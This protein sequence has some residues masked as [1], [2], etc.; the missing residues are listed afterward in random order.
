MLRE[1]FAGYRPLVT[2]T[3]LGAAAAVFD[4]VTAGLTARR[5]AGDLARLRDSALVTLGRTHARLVTALLGSTVASHLADAGHDDAEPWGAAMKAHG[6][7][8]A[9]S[10]TA[11]L[12]LLLG[13][14]GF[15]ADCRTAKTRRDLGGLLYADGIHDSLFRAAGKHHTGRGDNSVIP[16]PRPRPESVPTAAPVTA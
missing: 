9:D 11:E 16:T 7:D 3:A 5:A 2:A 4:T 13:A 14:A 10:I 15:R 8:T 6:V 1:H 12:A